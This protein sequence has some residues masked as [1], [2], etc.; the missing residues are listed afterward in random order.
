MG[1]S[2]FKTSKKIQSKTMRLIKMPNWLCRCNKKRFKWASSN[3][4]NS[5][6]KGECPRIRQSIHSLKS[7]RI[8][9][10][11][12][13]KLRVNREL[14]KMIWMVLENNQRLKRNQMLYS[15]FSKDVFLRNRNP[16]DTTKIKNQS[17]S[18][19]HPRVLWRWG[20]LQVKNLI[21]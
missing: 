6:E 1:R 10:R 4:D 20:H 14:I 3:K 21:E 18:R 16:Q 15:A 5:H 13:S 8:E 19:R 2:H 9:M 11:S 12:H 7:C 17:R